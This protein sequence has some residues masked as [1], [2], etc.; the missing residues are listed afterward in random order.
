MLT[1]APA[2][3]SR[4]R[5]GP[6]GRASTSCFA[7]RAGEARL[8]AGNATQRRMQFRA[9]PCAPPNPSIERTLSGLRPPSASHVK[10]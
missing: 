5:Q 2:S 3:R 6:S 7:A 9:V 8:L 4:A 10:R 1:E